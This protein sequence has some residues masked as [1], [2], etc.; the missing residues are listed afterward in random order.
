VGRHQLD[1]AACAIALLE[2]AGLIGVSVGEVAVREGLRSVVWEGRLEVLEDAPRVILDG[3]HNPAASRSLA[4]YLGEFLA[5]HPTARI[6]LVW[7]MMRDKDHREFLAPL[8]PLVS[9][10][11]LTEACLARSATVHE[12]HEPLREWPN[13]VYEVPLPAGALQMAKKRASPG[14]LI[15]VAGSLMLLGDIKAAVNGRGLSLI[16]G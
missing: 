9:E 7:G 16:R 2:S 5:S 8:L 6:I 11:V 12:L 14:D 13:P 10:I 15:C 3:A 4:W 1:N